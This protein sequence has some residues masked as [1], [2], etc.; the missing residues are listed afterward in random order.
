MWGAASCGGP[1]DAGKPETE[2]VT[3]AALKVDQKVDHKMDHDKDV[4]AAFVKQTNLVSNQEGHA[5]T[6]DD[7][8]D[9]NGEPAG[10]VNSWGLAF[11]PSGV[12][13]I[14]LNGSHQ[15][16]I[17]PSSNGVVN[18]G[19]KVVVPPQ[20]DSAPTGLLFNTNTSKFKGD[21]FITCTEDGTVAG[22]QPPVTN[23]AV[24]RVP[25]PPGDP[26]QGPVYKGMALF[27]DKLYVADFRDNKVAVFDDDYQPVKLFHGAFVDHK[28]PK[29]FAPFNIIVVGDVLF[30]SYAMQDDAR[31]DDVPGAGNGFINVFKPNGEFV[32]RLVSDGALDSPWG[33][34]IMSSPWSWKPPR[35]IVGNFGDGHVNVYELEAEHGKIEAESEGMLFDAPHHPLF[36][37]G[38]WALVFGPGVGD[39]DSQE[40]FFTA[41]PDGE[42]NGLFG[43]LT[44][45]W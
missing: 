39:F 15:L 3:S 42:A 37:D 28:L 19:P 5:P 10:L 29:G 33:M 1:N 45:K 31:H 17:Y 30:V 12:A 32:Q 20:G 35:L 18:I 2:A 40:L 24:I 6:F 14:A 27:H 7:G 38:L 8:T 26:D 44:F 11:A 4:V 16:G 13:W 22:W 36:I 21:V 43:K 23:P 25:A 34:A 41:G 9:S